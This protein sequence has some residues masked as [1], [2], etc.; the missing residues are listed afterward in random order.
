MTFDDAEV[1]KEHD[2]Y[3]G[4][5]KSLVEY[6]GREASKFRYRFKRIGRPE[7]LKRSMVGSQSC[8]DY[9]RTWR[10]NNPDKSRLYIHRSWRKR[11]MAEL[12]EEGL[13]TA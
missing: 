4:S 13:L 3:K 7:P 11:I 12:R 2:A 8:N 9:H 5:G 1:A 10:S 6:Y